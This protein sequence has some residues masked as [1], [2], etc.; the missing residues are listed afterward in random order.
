[1]NSHIVFVHVP[2]A[3]DGFGVDACGE[4]VERETKKI[5]GVGREL[6]KGMFAS[7][8]VT[9]WV[10]SKG[11]QRDSVSGVLQ[12]RAAGGRRY[13]HDSSE[14]AAQLRLIKWSNRI[15]RE[16]AKEQAELEA[17]KAKIASFK[18][19]NCRGHEPAGGLGWTVYC[20]GRCA[21]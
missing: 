21:N 10:D 17:I 15:L 20:N 12:A 2:K 8:Q 19:A 11:G 7:Y 6:P 3:R 14:S 9:R 4:A 13:F 18:P 1:M 5:A 16:I